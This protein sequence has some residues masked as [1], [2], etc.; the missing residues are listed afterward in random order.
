MKNKI[1]PIKLM[2]KTFF[3]E[4]KEKTKLIKFIKISEKLSMGNNVEKF[5]KKF[6]NF[7]NC[8]STTMVNSGS[9]ANLLLLQS[10]KNLKKIKNGDKIGFSALTWST[11]LMPIIQLGFEPVPID[12]NL[13]TL[14]ISPRNLLASLKK[15]KI[16][17]LFLTNVLGFSDDIM[18]ISR[19]CKKKKILLIED[20]C[21]SLGSEFK[22]KKLGTFGFAST[23]SFYV[24][25]HISSIEGG[26]VSTNDAKLS[27]MLKISRA[28][29]WLRNIKNNK[30]KH[31]IKKFK[32]NK[33]YEN[34]TF[35]D[36]G[37][38]LRPTEINGFIGFH[39]LSYLNL[40]ITKRYKN[41]K[42]FDKASNL[43]NAFNRLDL[44]NMNF[45][46]NFTYP[47]M[48]KTQNLFQEYTKKFKKDKIEI[49]PLIAGDITK[50]PFFK[51]YIKKKYNLPNTNYLHENA[52][53][54]P[55]RPDLSK[56]EIKRILSIL[57]S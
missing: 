49:R 30:R 31:Y 53:Y 57:N 39:Q 55:N 32:I 13:K 25:H 21:E 8:R 15:D 16:K 1:K 34:Y 19:I 43:N 28:H 22:G 38:N 40:I 24:G 46:S 7:L 52:F 14:N 20:N 50:Q 2:S 6:S 18:A 42:L 17:C 3:N 48:C 45:I 35:F 5:E 37:F 12:I 23:H 4:K 26:S 10:L 27:D 29:G 44:R 51:K 33:F 41:F 56:N 9:S 54:I 47:V 36:L 11:N